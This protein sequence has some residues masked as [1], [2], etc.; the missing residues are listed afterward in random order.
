MKAL[1]AIASRVQHQVDSAKRVARQTKLLFFEQVAY[2]PLAPNPCD[3][4]REECE[5]G[6]DEPICL[7]MVRITRSVF[8]QRFPFSIHF[9]FRDG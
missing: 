4:A 6:Q 7:C 8:H 9:P 3:V 2:I 1:V 5:Q